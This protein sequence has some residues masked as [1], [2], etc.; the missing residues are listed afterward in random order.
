MRVVFQTPS[1]MVALYLLLS[2]ILLL[3]SLDRTQLEAHELYGAP[4]I[5]LLSTGLLVYG[6]R[7]RVEP[8]SIPWLLGCLAA[9]S[10]LLAWGFGD[11]LPGDVDDVFAG[12]L[13]RGQLAWIMLPAA[14]LTVP[15]L[16][17]EVWT[18][19]RK[20]LNLRQGGGKGSPARQA[21]HSR[22][23]LA[24]MGAHLVHLGLLILIIGHIFAT[25]LVDRGAISHRLSL[26]EDNPV[27]EGD[28]VLVFSGL[29]V[30]SVGD[31]EFDSRFDVGV[32]YVGVVVEVYEIGD[33]DL[34]GDG[35]GSG[36][37]DNSVVLGEHIATLQPGVLRF[38]NG[39]ARSEVATMS[40]ASGDFI[41]IF[42]LSQASELGKAM[43]M[44]DLDEVER[45][46]VTAYNLPGSHLVWLGWSLMLIGMMLTWQSWW[47]APAF[48]V[49]KQYSGLGGETVQAGG[50]RVAGEE[51]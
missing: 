47:P 28:L 6:W 12:P 37:A 16:G 27:V 24:G 15:A 13:T 42:D 35:D 49:T 36:G 32:G 22:A 21:R 17:L 25:T 14:L 41:L 11:T 46:R 8:K 34:D 50:S 20:W 44:G 48:A 45:I 3:N 9:L 26:S 29:E 39:F 33:S 40:R 19:G 2:W 7:G 1:T 10:G 51:E 31:E 23:A 43:V 5:V 30:L 38:E 4:I 18:R